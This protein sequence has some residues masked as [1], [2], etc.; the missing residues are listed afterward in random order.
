MK[1]HEMSRWDEFDNASSINEKIS[2]LKEDLPVI[3]T[4]SMEIY[5]LLSKGIHKLTEEE[6]R[7]ELPLLQQSIEVIISDKIE[8]ANAIKS[9]DKMKKL[10]SQRAGHHQ[11]NNS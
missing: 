2:L 3:M 8:K 9:R 5:R 10:L 6:C 1:S 7:E 4:E 11:K